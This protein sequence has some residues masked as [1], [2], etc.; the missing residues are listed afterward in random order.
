[1]T[2]RISNRSSIKAISSLLLLVLLGISSVALAI[3][4]KVAQLVE[5][6][7]EANAAAKRSPLPVQMPHVEIPY[8]W[9][10]AD[11]AKRIDTRISSSLMFWRDGI[12]FVRWVLNP[13]DTRWWPEVIKYFEDEFKVKLEIKTHFIGYQTSSRSYIVEDPTNGAVFSVKSSTN[14]AGGQWKDKKQPVG[15]AQD[16]RIISDYL[17]KQGR[18]KKFKNFV[19]MDEPVVFKIPMIDQAVVVRDL[20][21]V[22]RSDGKFYYLPGFSALHEVAGRE[23]AEKNGSKDPYAFWTE[24]YIKVAGR[25][26]GELAAR[27]GLQF[28]SPHSQN[29]LIELDSTMK[30]TGRLVLRDMADFYIDK[31]FAIALEGPE[32]PLVKKFSQTSNVHNYI[33]AGFGPLHGNQK[34]S[35]VSD[36]QYASW[37]TVFFN[38]FDRVFAEVTGL[39][40]KPIASKRSMNGDYFMAHYELQ[41]SPRVD[42]FFMTAIDRGQITP[43]PQL[44]M[45]KVAFKGK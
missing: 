45:C 31:N 3:N 42:D 5:F 40:I 28:D 10:E 25:A 9:L 14:K 22:K 20:N 4:Q 7:T 30:P 37:M 6:E 41:K 18:K 29:F 19:I 39:E 38:E 27:T 26:L 34:P 11:M 1:M 2:H 23:I 24:N 21:D 32:S 8:L 17:Y 13:E 35:W 44:M 43:L 33:A 15:E 36:L 12:L 16:S